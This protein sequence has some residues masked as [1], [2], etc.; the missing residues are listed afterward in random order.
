[1]LEITMEKQIAAE[2]S[3]FSWRLKRW[4]K[5][6]MI[7]FIDRS[8]NFLPAGVLSITIDWMIAQL[9]NKIKMY[10]Q[11]CQVHLLYQ[12]RQELPKMQ[13]NLI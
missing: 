9:F 13:K 12:G 7:K 5:A 10:L 8:Y 2:C 3:R 4:W 1:M 6:L 11:G